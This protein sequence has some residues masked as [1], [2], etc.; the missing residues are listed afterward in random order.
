MRRAANERDQWG[1]KKIGDEVNVK[2]DCTS[3]VKI[4]YLNRFPYISTIE[5][6]IRQ[7]IGPL[8][9]ILP[10]GILVFCMVRKTSDT[11]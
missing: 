7:G 9:L 10:G 6:D 2:A 3:A 11:K 5:S 4:R 8:T 1:C